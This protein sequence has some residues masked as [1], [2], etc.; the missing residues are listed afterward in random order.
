MSY[1]KKIL[2][3]LGVLSGLILGYYLI[4]NNSKN[5]LENKVP[6]AILS[7]ESLVN[8]FIQNQ[9]RAADVYTKKVLLVSGTVKEINTLNNR[10]TLYLQTSNTASIICDVSPTQS[11]LFYQIKKGQQIVI[12]GICK[13][14]LKD[15]ILQNCII[16]LNE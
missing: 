4:F 3:L 9:S 1:S 14:F 7:S 15:V 11:E 16:E 8:A 5:Q 2:V 10:F 6:E 12:K 13:G